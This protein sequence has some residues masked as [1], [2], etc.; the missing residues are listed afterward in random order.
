[1]FAR[2]APTDLR[3]GF[4]GL[5]GLVRCEHGRDM[6]EGDW[7]LFVSWRRDSA[8]GWAGWR[9]GGVGAYKRYHKTIKCGAIRVTP[10]TT[11][12][13]ARETITRFV[14]HYNNT[15]LHSAIGYITP[16]DRMEGRQND[17]RD[18]RDRKLEAARALRA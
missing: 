1:M 13:E 4:V 15:R 8:A 17:I 7:F 12:E 3:L 10:P 6:L 9:R 2:A 14:D 11:I 18:E 5:S 16:K